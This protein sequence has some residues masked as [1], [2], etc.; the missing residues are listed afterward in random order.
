MKLPLKA[1][2]PVLKYSSFGHRKFT[3]TISDAEGRTVATAYSR[4]TAERI[5]DA[6]N[7]RDKQLEGLKHTFGHLPPREKR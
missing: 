4:T 6:L 3:I 7:K 5:V 1:L 2:E